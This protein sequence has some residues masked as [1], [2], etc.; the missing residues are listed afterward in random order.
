[1]ILTIRRNR[2][3]HEKDMTIEDNITKYEI[4]L[5]RLKKRK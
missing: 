5:F 2:L 3:R 4:N 1:M